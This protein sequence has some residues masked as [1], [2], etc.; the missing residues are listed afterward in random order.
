MSSDNS[1]F[2]NATCQKELKIG[3]IQSNL[4]ELAKSMGLDA[5]CVQQAKTEFATGTISGS[6]SIPFAK[7]NLSAGFNQSNNS[8]AQSGCGQFMLNAKNVLNSTNA[9]SCTLNQTGNTQNINVTEN[10]TVSI[11]I[12]VS[13]EAV[14]A[15]AENLKLAQENFN[16]IEQMITQATIMGSSKASTDQLQMI[17]QT[18]QK[19]IDNY[20]PLTTTISNSTIK[21]TGSLNVKDISSVS[22][23][24]R[25][26][27]QAQFN[28]IAKASAENHLQS[29]LGTA[30]LS[31]NVKQVLDQ[32]IKSNSSQY[33]KLINSTLNSTSIQSN[34]SGGITIYSNIPLNLDNVTIDNNIA[35]TVAVTALT[36]NAAAAG[37]SAATSMLTQ[38]MSTSSTDTSSSGVDD[39]AK[40]L[41]ENQSNFIKANQTSM[42]AIVYIVIAIIALA[43]IGGGIYAVNKNPELLKRK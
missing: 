8:M 31:P 28:D 41:G 15:R 5:N 40:Q 43:V 4:P 10:S 20:K 21:N 14:K 33:Q 26:Q 30:A 25:N 35:V 3:D 29:H 38:A 27:L 12:V 37:L 2:N 39:L 9:M 17:L 18:A 24:V 23:E 36:T 11:K 19:N 1:M 13:D 32:N 34:G 7:A 22:A 42:G 6:M 16:K